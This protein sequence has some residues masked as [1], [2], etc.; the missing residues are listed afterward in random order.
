MRKTINHV[1]LSFSILALLLGVE[2]AP[3]DKDVKRMEEELEEDS[4]RSGKF[5]QSIPGELL[6]GS[7]WRLDGEEETL[8]QTLREGNP[9]E[10]L[11]A[12]RALW[13]G[14]SRR[15]ASQVL[16]FL[17]DPPQGGEAY[18]AFQREVEATLEPQAIRRQL[19][20]GD[21]PWGT[22]LAF[23]RPHKE[24]VPALLEGLKDRPED[25]ETILALG[26]SGDPRVL[27][28]LLK[29]LEVKDF[30]TPGHAAQA[31]GYLGSPEAEPA[32]LKALNADNPWLQVKACGALAKI[33]TRRAVPALKQLARDDSSHGIMNVR[34]RAQDAL[35]RIAKREALRY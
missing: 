16:K 10:Q 29:L 27:P 25:P 20:W 17:A 30:T 24:L 6:R 13:R 8:V 23:L 26:N 21:Y 28:L 19:K 14:H 22:W 11:A 4:A 7:S 9:E 5:S 1:T 35:E 15:Y 33:G 31:L 32:L 34:S 18:R 3:A 12:A 2:Q